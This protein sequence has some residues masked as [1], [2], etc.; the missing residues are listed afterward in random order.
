MP[1]PG[2]KS[3]V[4]LKE[5]FVAAEIKLDTSVMARLDAL[6]NERTV[7]GGRYNTATQAEIDTET[8]AAEV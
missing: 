1:I 3:I 5:N 7:H 4:H 6:I 2:T 8:F